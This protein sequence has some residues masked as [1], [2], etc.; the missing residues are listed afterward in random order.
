MKG[1]LCL[2]FQALLQEEPVASITRG[3][4]YE[5]MDVDVQIEPFC[6]QKEIHVTHSFTLLSI[7]C[8]VKETCYLKKEREQK[9]KL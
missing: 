1:E 4:N 5:G 9:E 2:S 6:G 8:I 3:S 7:F